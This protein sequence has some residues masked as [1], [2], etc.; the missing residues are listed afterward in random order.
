MLKFKKEY[1]LKIVSLLSAA[2]FLL[3]TAVYAR[4]LSNTFS[5]RVP[6][7]GNSQ[8]LIAVRKEMD[9]RQFVKKAALFTGA[10]LLTGLFSSD[11]STELSFS[12]YISNHR[13]PQQGPM[14]VWTKENVV[15]NRLFDENKP[16]LNLVINKNMPI[17]EA[18]LEFVENCKPY[19]DILLDKQRL[20]ILITELKSENPAIRKEN[21][22]MKG[23]VLN[24]ANLYYS[25]VV[26]DMLD[27]SEF[28]ASYEIKINDIEIE[29]NFVNHGSAE[30][31]GLTVSTS[32]KEYIFI[33]IGKLKW[34]AEEMYK[35]IVAPASMREN[36]HA[37]EYRN[38]SLEKIFDKDIRETLFHEIIHAATDRGIQAGLFNGLLLNNKVIRDE[39]ELVR[40][41]PMGN[42][43]YR[44]KEE[45][46]AI[47]GQ[48]AYSKSDRS[49][50]ELMALASIGGAGSDLNYASAG[51][52]VTAL[53][54][55]A[56]G[57]GDFLLSQGVEKS[58]ESFTE[59][60]GD[61]YL[62]PPER[63]VY[64]LKFIKTLS[65]AEIHRIAKLYYEQLFGPLPQEEL[66]RIPKKVIELQGALMFKLRDNMTSFCL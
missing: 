25:L 50:L 64:A 51:H 32:K 62:I 49:T 19:I 54:F 40:K 36:F 18:I 7:A 15:L 46:A 45:I 2:V 39:I 16:I 1:N 9:R 17:Q 65:N 52:C 37:E 47:L 48:L 58:K 13:R 33:D 55:D 21:L 63:H 14:Q 59:W 8:R 28:I 10:V 6:L 26:L 43:I 31:G 30:P 24:A 12:D 57:F 23:T 42:N 29:I 38:W 61:T 5:L 27:K 11:T 66:V 41:Y 22:L 35:T 53:I 20:N 44:I 3:N 34:E 4:G 60:V 56:L